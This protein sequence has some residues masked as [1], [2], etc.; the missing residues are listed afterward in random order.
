MLILGINC[1]GH[2]SSAAIILDGELIAAAEEER[3]NRIKQYG[4]VPLSAIRYCLET[5]GCRYEDLDHVGYYWRPLREAGH[6]AMHFVRHFP[7][8]L[9]L[10]G[11]GSALNMSYRRRLPAMLALPSFLKKTFNAKGGGPRFHYLEHHLAH[12]ASTFFVSPFEEAAILTMDGYGEWPTALLAVGRGSRIEKIEQVLFPHSLGFLYSAI[13]HH[14]GFKPS[15]EEWI[16]MGLAPYGEPRYQSIFKKVLRLKD[17]GTF[18]LDLKYFGF[19]THG[20]AR[21]LSPQLTKELG[22]PRLA[23]EPIEQRHKDIARSLQLC[24][25]DAVLHITRVLQR[26]TKQQNLCLAGGVALNSVA[27]GRVLLEGPFKSVY[28]TPAAADDGTAVGSAFFLLHQLL[29]RKRSWQMEHAY[30]GPSFDE[31]AIDAAIR[32][33]G[34]QAEIVDDPAGHAADL[35]AA[36]WIIGWFQGRM[37]FGARA[38]GNRSILADPRRA[39]VKDEINAKVKYRESFR[40]FAPAVLEERT[41]DYFASLHPAPF[42]TLVYPVLPEKRAIIP[43]VTHVDGTARPQT[44][45]RRTNPLFWDLIR[46]FEEK[47]G[48]PVVLN[49]SFNVKGEPIVCSPSDAMRTFHQSRLDAVII[50]N[51]LVKRGDRKLP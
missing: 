25:E 49:T 42:M 26:R 6:L 21:W 4:G 12:A 24:L 48:V 16:V 47:T 27:N 7:G 46:K 32:E 9:G 28:V 14:L 51:R 10:L 38:L 22:P 20:A 43:A 35:L 2:D 15:S 44:V 29:G 37:E 33:A 30:F 39:E 3:F 36:G 17:N 18:Q 50:G 45:S 41:G 23:S 1:Y 8:S 13:T 34:E 31:A 11:G 19:H 5:V 40:P